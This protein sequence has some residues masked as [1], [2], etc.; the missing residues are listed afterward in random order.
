MHP[1]PPLGQRRPADPA[2]A[3]AL[4]CAR[5]ASAASA[6]TIGELLLRLN[7]MASIFWSSLF[8]ALPADHPVQRR[9]WSRRSPTRSPSPYF[10]AMAI[11]LQLLRL[12]GASTSLRDLRLQPAAAAG[13]PGGQHQ[14]DG[15]GADRRQG[16]LPAHAEGPQPHRRRPSSSSSLPYAHRRAGGLHRRCTP[17]TTIW[18]ERGRSRR[19]TRCSAPTRSSPSSASATRS[20]T[21]GSTSS[22]GSTSRRAEE[23]GRP[24][25]RR[26]GADRRGRRQLGTGPLPRPRR[27]PPPS[28]GKPRKPPRSWTAPHYTLPVSAPVVDPS[29]LGLESL[30]P[31]SS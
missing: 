28:P 24:R 17:T 19:S 12:Q 4:R 29:D 1:A 30:A 18:G 16:Q 14:L 8:A 31:E 3:V 20:S 22:P 9:T 13:Q 7:Y 21:S 23:D 25:A 2:E 26:A 5:G 10:L 6:P 15:A 27:P 11:D